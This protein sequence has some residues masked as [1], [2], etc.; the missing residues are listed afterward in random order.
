MVGRSKPSPSEQ[1]KPA[2]APGWGKAVHFIKSAF[3]TEECLESLKRFL[4]KAK[5]VLAVRN[6]DHG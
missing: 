3:F 1:G 4:Y 2:C 6:Q 5:L